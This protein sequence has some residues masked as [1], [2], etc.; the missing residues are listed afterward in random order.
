MGSEADEVRSSVF[1]CCTRWMSSVEIDKVGELAKRKM[2]AARV[3]RCGRVKKAGFISATSPIAGA[4]K[5]SQPE[6]TEPVDAPEVC[7]QH[8]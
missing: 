4:A 8:S 2:F 1:R 3:A 5:S 6:A 7:E